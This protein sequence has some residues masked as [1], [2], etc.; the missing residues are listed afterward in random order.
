MIVLARQLR[1]HAP[2]AHCVDENNVESVEL[3][4]RR[5]SW[6]S[7]LR[8]VRQVDLP[9]A[10]YTRLSYGQVRLSHEWQKRA[11]DH[12]FMVIRPRGRVSTIDGPSTCRRVIWKTAIS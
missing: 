7:A 4:G 9:D 11:P 10:L 6:Q 5:S 3:A 1:P 12:V 2:R 8:G